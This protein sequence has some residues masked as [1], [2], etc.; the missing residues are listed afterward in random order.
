MKRTEEK[1]YEECKS[2]RPTRSN[3][4]FY[5]LDMEQ[6]LYS[7][8]QCLC[9]CVCLNNTRTKGNPSWMR[10]KL[11]RPHPQLRRF[12]QYSSSVSIVNDLCHVQKSTQCFSAPS[13]KQ[14]T[15]LCGLNNLYQNRDLGYSCILYNNMY[16]IPDRRFWYQ[17]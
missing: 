7:E 17:I 3:M 2:C 13:F 14:E 4:N 5:L 11:I 16:C 9:A 15:E 1:R 10:E 12:W 6:V 8:T